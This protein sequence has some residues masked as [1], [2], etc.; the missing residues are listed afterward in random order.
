MGAD[1]L[2]YGIKRI[3]RGILRGQI[4]KRSENAVAN[5]TS[6]ELFALSDQLGM[7]KVMCCKYRAAAQEC[8]DQS[9]KPKLE[10]YAN[11]HKQNYDC[12]LGYLK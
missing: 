10:Q 4:S 9:I 2:F 5:L 3:R 7:E 11:Q 8:T 1:T 6:K 12:L